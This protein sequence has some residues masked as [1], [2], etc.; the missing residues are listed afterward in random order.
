PFAM[1]RIGE[2]YEHGVGVRQKRDLSKSLYWYRRA[3]KGGDLIAS[4]A[5]E[6]MRVAFRDAFRRS[7]IVTTALSGIGLLTLVLHL[8]GVLPLATG[9]LTGVC[10]LG[11][12]AVLGKILRLLKQ[13]FS[14]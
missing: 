13:Y 12:L 2:M 8:F 11:D 6:R 10:L 4:G 5:L 14:L 9:I 7:L 3:S 1:T